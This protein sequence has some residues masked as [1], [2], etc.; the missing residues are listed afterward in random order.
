[1][2]GSAS[3]QWIPLT[4]RIRETTTVIVGGQPV[5]TQ[6]REGILYRRSDGSTLTEWA[7]VNGDPR[8]ASSH[9]VDYQK[10][11][12]YEI[13]TADRMALERPALPVGISTPPRPQRF[14]RSGLRE[15]VVAGFACVVVPHK[16]I[17]HGRKMQ[18]HMQLHQD[19]VACWSNQYNLMLRL[20][21]QRSGVDG[22]VYHQLYEVVSLDPGTEPDP[23]LFDVQ[24]RG[25]TVYKTSPN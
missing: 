5:E 1:M 11:S 18:D 9:L 8:R 12:S 16:S 14:E 4:A 20:N 13:K 6:T 19:G 7:H 23:K 2:E 24:A 25:F 22:K 21:V 15:E 3:A 17:P 10:N